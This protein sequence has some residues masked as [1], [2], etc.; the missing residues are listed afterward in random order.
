VIECYYISVGSL[1]VGQKSRD[2][3][4]VADSQLI[5]L[6]LNTLHLPLPR[7]IAVTSY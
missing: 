1:P 4:V 2:H 5:E 7:P 6:P 3:S